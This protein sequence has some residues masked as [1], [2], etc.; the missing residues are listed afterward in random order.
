MIR[1]FTTPQNVTRVSGLSAEEVETFIYHFTYESAHFTSELVRL[2]AQGAD[3]RT[4]LAFAACEVDAERAG[5][6]AVPSHP[7]GTS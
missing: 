3:A 5:S 7:Q 2:Y 6:L 4:V 1:F